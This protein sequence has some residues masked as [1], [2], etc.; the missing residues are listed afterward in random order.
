MKGMEDVKLT[1]CKICGKKAA[2]IVEG[3]ET[4][5]CAKHYVEQ[6]DEE[7]LKADL[8][9]D[10]EDHGKIIEP[11]EVQLE[12]KKQKPALYEQLKDYFEV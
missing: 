10:I 8:Q 7:C 9:M 6:E 3:G 5:L 1:K 11:K 2:K 12:I 4:Q